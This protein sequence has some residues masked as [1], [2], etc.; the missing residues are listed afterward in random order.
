M[1]EQV[2]KRIPAL[3]AY[4][5]RIGAEQLSFQRFMVKIYKGDYYFERAIIHVLDDGSVTCS[6]KDYAP[7]KAEAELIKAAC[8]KETWPHAIAAPHDLRGLQEKLMPGS[9]Y[10]EFHNRQGETVMIQER[11]ITT[12]GQRLFLPWTFW[13]DGVWRCMEP[14]GPLPF[15]KPQPTNKPNI[16]IHEGAKAAFAVDAMTRDVHCE[17]PWLEELKCFEHWGIIGGALAVH[18]ANYGE[19]AAA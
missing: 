3:A 12:K 8:I 2:Y 14:G 6:N 4:I 18:R 5:D 13:S 9:T 11:A 7:T 1:F 19:L 15:W 17:H 16:M 10:Y